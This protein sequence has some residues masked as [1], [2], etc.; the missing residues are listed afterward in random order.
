MNIRKVV[1]VHKSVAKPFSCSFRKQDRN[2]VKLQ[3]K[4]ALYASIGFCLV[5]VQ[6]L[7]ENGK[8]Y[9]VIVE[10]IDV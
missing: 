4:S 1:L 9:P 10:L 2:L 6:C 3:V 5:V 7:N 8:I